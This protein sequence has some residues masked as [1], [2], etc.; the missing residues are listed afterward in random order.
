MH[1][2]ELEKQL[3]DF[4]FWQTVPHEKFMSEKLEAIHE[5]SHT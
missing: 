4:A 3:Q 2:T 5:H 1:I